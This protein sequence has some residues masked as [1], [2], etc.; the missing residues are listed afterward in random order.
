[1]PRELHGGQGC[2]R[3]GTPRG[4]RLCAR[5]RVP[6]AAPSAPGVAVPPDCTS[7]PQP[8]NGRSSLRC[9]GGG[10]P[11]PRRSSQ[12]PEAGRAGTQGDIGPR[13]AVGPAR[14]WY[15]PGAG[16]AGMEGKD[17]GS[18]GRRRLRICAKGNFPIFHPVGS[19]T[20]GMRRGC[21][22]R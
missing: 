14:G 18:R 19:S 10:E 15:V 1:M 16:V 20:A 5:G 22:F 3:S 9:R 13:H 8:R 2:T 21:P 6:A 11:S 7:A 12:P 4:N 17:L